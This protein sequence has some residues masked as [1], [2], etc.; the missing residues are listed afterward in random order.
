MCVNGGIM[1]EPT[2]RTVRIVSGEELGWSLYLLLHG[3]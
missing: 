3:R 2:T 1:S